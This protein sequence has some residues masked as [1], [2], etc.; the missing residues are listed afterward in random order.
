MRDDQHRFL[1][2]LEQL[3]ARLT[4]EQTAWVLKCQPHDVSILV[5]A[6]LLK[7]LGNPPSNGVKFF[8][9]KEVLEFAKDEKCLHRVRVAIYQRRHTRNERKKVRANVVGMPVCQKPWLATDRDYRID[10]LCSTR[11]YRR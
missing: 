8:A 3:P 4:V 9:S 1:V 11:D 5:A 10:I 6:R 2:L 7:P